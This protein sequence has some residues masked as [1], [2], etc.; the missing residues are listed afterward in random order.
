MNNYTTIY[1]LTRLD[2]IQ[3][4]LITL[5]M[6]SIGAV[7]LYFMAMM[8]TC[9]DQEA[10]TEYSKRFKKYRNAS[11]WCIVISSLLLVFVPSKN[12]IILIYAGGK[13]MDYIKTD[14][15]LTKIPYQA[16]SIIS[17]Y[18]DQ[19]INELKETK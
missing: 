18:L 17:G 15:S 11:F 16:T 13:T 10:F 19:K 7:V 1:W 4:L 3:G 5:L 14:T 6:L 8:F 12:D 9:Y 2:H